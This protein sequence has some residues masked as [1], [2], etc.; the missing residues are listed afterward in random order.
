MA[1]LSYQ[2]RKNLPASDFVFPKTRKY[3]IQDHAHA[4]NALA[5]V[6]QF[7]SESEKVAV[8]AAVRKR[9]PELHMGS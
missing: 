2:A 9:Y 6:S 3:P 1:K 7:G 4:V 8:R 5:R